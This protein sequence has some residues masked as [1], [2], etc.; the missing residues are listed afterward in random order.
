MQV[1]LVLIGDSD[2]LQALQL[3]F[4]DILYFQTLV[5]DALADLATLLQVVKAVLLRV[6]GVHADLVSVKKSARK[7][8]HN[9]KVSLCFSNLVV[10]QIAVLAGR[11]PCK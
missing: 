1:C 2:L 11:R 6:L 4:L 10:N 8:A 7:H 9:N 3:L 5:F